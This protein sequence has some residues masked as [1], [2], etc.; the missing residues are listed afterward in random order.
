MQPGQAVRTGDRDDIAVREVDKRLAGDEG[1]L[2]AQIRAVVGRDAG[3]QSVASTAPGR[4]SSGLRFR[5]MSPEYVEWR[6]A[7]ASRG[8]MWTDLLS[9]EPGMD[10]AMKGAG[11]ERQAIPVRR[12]G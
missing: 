2:L 9:G 8:G 4:S 7:N 10:D 11:D 1:P 3:V 12:G 6:T 5:D